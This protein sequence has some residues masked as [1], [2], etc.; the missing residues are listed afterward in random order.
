MRKRDAIRRILCDTF[1]LPRPPFN[2]FSHEQVSLS[3]NTLYIA[4]SVRYKHTT[5]CNIY[6][7]AFDIF[8]LLR[9]Q[10]VEKVA[11]TSSLWEQIYTEEGKNTAAEF[12]LE[13]IY[14]A[15]AGERERARVFLY[16]NILNKSTL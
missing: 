11:C 13:H 6:F 12:L 15:Q 8:D 5:T 2:F 16:I 3:G 14:I 10:W 1:F 4:H 9:I 7:S